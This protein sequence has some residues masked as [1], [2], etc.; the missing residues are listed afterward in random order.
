ME[1][2]KCLSFCLVGIRQVTVWLL[3]IMI[4]KMNQTWLAEQDPRLYKGSRPT[5]NSYPKM[6]RT[7]GGRKCYVAWEVAVDSKSRKKDGGATSVPNNYRMVKWIIALN[8]VKSLIRM[9][10]KH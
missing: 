3:I 5:T 10:G 9:R 8:T 7:T 6:K 2:F 4:I 1:S